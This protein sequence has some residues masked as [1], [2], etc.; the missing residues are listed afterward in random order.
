[1][2]QQIP[3]MPVIGLLVG[4]AGGIVSAFVAL[5]LGAE[6]HSPLLGPPFIFIG[7]TCVYVGAFCLIK[8][9]Q[10]AGLLRGSK[11]DWIPPRIRGVFIVMFG[12]WWTLVGVA[13]V[14]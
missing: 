7:L 8:P 10:T 2:R 9:T 3:V 5:A 13:A 11:V 1:M 6:Y 4:P 14:F 12:L